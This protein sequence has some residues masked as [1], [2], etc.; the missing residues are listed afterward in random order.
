ME[1]AGLRFLRVSGGCGGSG[2]DGGDGGVPKGGVRHGGGTAGHLHSGA[3]G[4]VHGIWPGGRR[5][6][7]YAR[8]RIYGGLPGVNCGVAEERGEAEKEY[9]VRGR[10]RGASLSWVQGAVRVLAQGFDFST[11]RV[12]A[13]DGF[14][15]RLAGDLSVDGGQAGVERR[16]PEIFQFADRGRSEFVWAGE[17]DGLAG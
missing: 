8:G 5:G 11:E 16:H 12:C 9:R 3:R 1:E 15:G 17:G 2:G 13:D 4:L 10:V 6:S 14:A 7:G